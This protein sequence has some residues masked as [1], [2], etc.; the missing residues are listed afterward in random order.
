M[1][2]H[3]AGFE[4]V[5]EAAIGDWLRV[6]PEPFLLSG[7]IGSRQGWVEVPYVPCPADPRAVAHALTPVRCRGRTGYICP[8]LSCLDMT[9][10][11]DVLRGEEVQ[12]FGGLT[13][14]GKSSGSSCHPGTH[15]K[16]ISIE[17][18][19]V[20]GFSTHMTGE[21]FA[22]LRDYSILGR[23]MQPSRGLIGKLSTRAVSE[24]RNRAACFT[25]SSGPERG[26]S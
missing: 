26:S 10:V 19:N 24:Q 7:M 15:S 21:L 9:G 5:L 16:H 6:D 11:P 3:G 18:G 14:V 25:I 17:A 8:G 22:L 1:A 2:A 23:T 12:V 4:T 13:A 20:I